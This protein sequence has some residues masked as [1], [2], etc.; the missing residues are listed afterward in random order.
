MQ[1]QRSCIVQFIP[2]VYK[3]DVMERGRTQ[4]IQEFEKKKVIIR[5]ALIQ[6]LLE[7]GSEFLRRLVDSNPM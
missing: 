4:D 7:K 3:V 1:A 6:E 2:G 5:K